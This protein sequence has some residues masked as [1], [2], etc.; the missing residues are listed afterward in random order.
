MNSDML[1]NRNWGGGSTFNLHM[2]GRWGFNYDRGPSPK[3]KFCCATPEDPGLVIEQYA[4]LCVTRVHPLQHCLCFIFPFTKEEALQTATF[5]PLL[6]ALLNE[7]KHLSIHMWKYTTERKKK[8]RVS[9][10]SFFLTV[11]RKNKK[12]ILRVLRPSYERGKSTGFCSVI[13]LEMFIGFSER[14]IEE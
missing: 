6:A 9:V 11:K 5:T 12:R 14:A 10:Q 4:L 2:H 7:L 1:E 13:G 8:I 3:V